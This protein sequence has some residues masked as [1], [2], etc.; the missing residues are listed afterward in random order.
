MQ[1]CHHLMLA[2]NGS[3]E[4]LKKKLSYEPKLNPVSLSTKMRLKLLTTY[5]ATPMKFPAPE[6]ISGDNLPEFSTL[7][8]L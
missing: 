8:E 5:L 7:E 1:V 4:Y 6:N 2:E 3:M